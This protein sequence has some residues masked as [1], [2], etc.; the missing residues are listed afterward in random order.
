MDF[1]QASARAETLRAELN[2]HNHRYHV[3]DDPAVPDAE[4]DRLLRELIA[5]EAAYP[6]LI[7]PHSPT[8]RVGAAPLPEFRAVKHSVPML[9]LGNAFS[10]EDLR[11]FN[12]RVCDR[13]GETAIDYAAEVKLDGL[14]VSI[15]YEN[16]LLTLAATRGDGHTG[17]EVTHNIKTIS[18]VP[19][20]L[21]G[22]DMPAYL[23][24]RGE[25]FM[26]RAG[27][28]AL[29]DKQR[30]K[31]EKPFANPRNAAA[32]SLRQL[33]AR[34][35]ARRPLSF[36]AYGIGEYKG[37]AALQSHTRTL[38]L[39]RQWGLPTISETGEA[40]GV[41][42][43][44][45]YYAQI[46]G[47]RAAL[48]YDIDGVVFK[49]NDINRQRALGYISRAPRWAVAW[50]FPATEEMTQL[51]AI[52]VQV[53]R[54]GALT[55][56]ARLAPVTVAGARI[57][58]ATLHNLDEIRRK[59]I[60]IGDWVIIRRAGDVIPEVAGVI[61]AKRGAVTEFQMPEHCPV[62]G[63]G[64]ARE[65]GEAVFR[66]LGGL[67]CRAQS[68]QAIRHFVSRKALNIDGLGEKL[69]IRLT[70]TG[71]VKSV[72]DLYML[73]AGALAEL[74]R[75]GKKSAE[76]LIAARDKSRA[77]TLERFIYALGIREVGEATARLLA[78]HFTTLDRLKAATP[79]ALAEID[80]IG[81]VAARNIHGFFQEPHNLAII[82]RLLAAG[83][84]WETRARGGQARPLAGRS[85]VLTGALQGMTRA[86]ARQLLLQA[87]AKVS[88]SVSKKTDY[89]VYG[90][91][92]GSKYARAQSLDIPT[93]NEAELLALIGGGQ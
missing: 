19:L 71:L 7:T 26:T 37:K 38:A 62:C 30:E 14:A 25:V 31:G 79:E 3:L 60:Q 2:R 44:L 51:L 15:V 52:E 78:E 56:V 74:E 39:L 93:L 63:A 40:K 54:T 11:A 86:E 89:V 84:H 65:E 22:Q 88:G 17:E 18:A 69:I 12:K 45:Q 50:K 5:L 85:F 43:C 72:A 10:A 55:P 41:E 77:T 92:P 32:G 87:G 57:T 75:M 24:A 48:P 67:S 68:I 83:I 53:G 16:G 59:D 42:Q 58:N 46:D 21:I 13:L 70:E 36:F 28:R 27:F 35:T 47:R 81:P 49:V 73:T 6:P 23:E 4:Y 34:I 8:Q 90:E 20:S 80:N 76:N 66:C 9:S 91:N 1:K 61:H 82:D 33:D 29:N 64:V